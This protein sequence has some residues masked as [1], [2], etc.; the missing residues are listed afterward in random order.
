MGTL[1][2]PAP[3]ETLLACRRTISAKAQHVFI[4][5]CY[6]QVSGASGGLPWALRCPKTQPPH[7]HLASVLVSGRGHIVVNTIPTKRQDQREEQE[8][9]PIIPKPSRGH[10]VQ[11]FQKQNKTKQGGR[12]EGDFPISLNDT[13]WN[14]PLH[15]AVNPVFCQ[16]RGDLFFSFNKLLNNSHWNPAISLKRLEKTAPVIWK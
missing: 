3:F 6:F 5:Q 7:W 9:E 13:F 16:E 12:D 4:C 11:V 15:A 10:G 1:I 8:C 2:C 14:T